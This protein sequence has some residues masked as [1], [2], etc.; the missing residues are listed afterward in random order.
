[1]LSGIGLQLSPEKTSI[2][3]IDEGFDFL[4]FRI[5][6]RRKRGT[7]QRYTYTTPSR[8]AVASARA[9]I[10]A[11]TSTI[12]HPDFG[13]LLL[14]LNRFLRGWSSYFQYGVSSQVFDRLRHYTWQRVACWLRRERQ[15]SWSTI[16]R[17]YMIGWEY[18]TSTGLTLHKPKVAGVRYRYRGRNIPTPWTP[19][20]V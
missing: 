16:R 1:V 2:V 11:L 6:R 8:R 5:Q 19:Q 3:H 12:K 20:D 15:A 17:R 7:S 13:V 10:K 18:R 14:H 4:G 9:R